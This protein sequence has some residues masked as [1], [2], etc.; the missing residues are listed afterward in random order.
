MQQMLGRT[1]CCCWPTS[2][3]RA[4]PML[5]QRRWQQ[6]CRGGWAAIWEPQ[7]AAQRPIAAYHEPHTCWKLGLI[8]QL[9]P[10]LR[11][12]GRGDGAVHWVCRVTSGRT[13]S[14]PCC[15]PEGLPALASFLIARL[16]GKTI[17]SSISLSLPFFL[18]SCSL[19]N[20]ACTTFRSICSHVS[21]SRLHLAPN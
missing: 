5:W 12:G 2:P 9:G 19:A 20:I 8:T 3:A 18:P 21:A 16:P 6:L 15:L 14:L 11:W 4:R 1:L 17:F 7:A 10:T 13:P